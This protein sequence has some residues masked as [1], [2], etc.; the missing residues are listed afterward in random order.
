MAVQ[1]NKTSL[2][3]LKV[4]NSFLRSKKI[5][6]VSFSIC[7]KCNQVKRMHSICKCKVK[8]LNLNK[9]MFI[10]SNLKEKNN[11]LNKISKFNALKNNFSVYYTSKDIPWC[12]DK[13]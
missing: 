8:Q 2:S 7:L 11:Y 5:N 12:W 6:L 10:Y 4:R 9:R 1:K 13:V 3:K